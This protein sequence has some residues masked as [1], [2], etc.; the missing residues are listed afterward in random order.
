MLTNLILFFIII[1]IIIYF[2]FINFKKNFQWLIGNEDL[3]P[4]FSKQRYS[5]FIKNSYHEV[6]GW[7]RKPS[8]SGKE[9]SQRN[10]YFVIN[11]YGFRGERSFKK[12]T[13][14]VFGDSFAFCRYVNDNETWEEL[15]S[16]KIK[17]N[18][19]NFGVGNYGIDQAYIKYKI[20]KNK[21]KTKHIIFCV[22]P[23]TIARIHSHWKHYREFGNIFGFKPLINFK[24]NKMKIINIPKIKIQKNNVKNQLKFNQ[25]LINH[26]QNHDIF[27]E[28]K[29]KSNILKFPY[30]F[31][32]VKNFNINA[33]IFFFLILHSLTKKFNEKN[34]KFYDYAKKVLLKKNIIDSHNLY[35]NY[36]YCK[37]LT[38]IFQNI[39]LFCKK[40]RLEF[41]IVIIPQYL[42]I[43]LN[44]TNN[45]YI[46]FY[47][48]LG[49]KNIFEITNDIIKKKNWESYYFND[50]Y[51]GHLNSKG[52]RLVSKIILNKIKNKY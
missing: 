50:K 1:E 34:T 49:N 31:Y 10:S 12:D 9:K 51:G 21:I 28:K 52:N 23:E 38:K 16:Q 36:N 19:L 18:V 29:F 39:E 15:L 32:F 40:K 7:D 48:N 17:S 20:I 3:N 11:K 4:K 30:F 33:P 22:V 44:K 14:A 24:N 43:K 2:L 5:N 42:D 27:Y 6:L 35:E 45:K 46:N 47:K 26:F 37:N 25:K 41:S 8:T 13:I